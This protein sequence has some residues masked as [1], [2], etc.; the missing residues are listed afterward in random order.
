[1]KKFNLFIC[2]VLF[3]CSIFISNAKAGELCAFDAD[4]QFIGHPYT[5]EMY[6]A[7]HHLRVYIPSLNVLAVFDVYDFEWLPDGTVQII[8]KGNLWS[9][10]PR[11]LQTLSGEL[12]LGMPNLLTYIDNCEGIRD[13]YFISDTEPQVKMI[14]KEFGPSGLESGNLCEITEWE[15]PN[16][17]IVF[18]TKEIPASEMP[19]TLPLKLPLE[20]RY[21]DKA[22]YKKPNIF[23]KQG[24]KAKGLKR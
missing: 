14:N 16:S 1:M 15:P 11:L 5:P 20:F 18:K 13:T 10:G 12:Y 23:L 7:L 24:R 2:T 17:S 6:E 3:F 19:F 9:R 21:V 22:C 8:E 4:G